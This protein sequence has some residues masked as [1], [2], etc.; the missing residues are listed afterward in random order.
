[1]TT[2]VFGSG[3]YEEVLG[4]RLRY[5]CGTPICPTGYVQ[6]N[7]LMY[8]KKKIRKYTAE[9]R[10][11]IHRNLKFDETVMTSLHMLA[12]AYL[13]SRSVEYMDNRV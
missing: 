11:E 10:E 1:M 4:I 13:P 8:K 9:G 2:K 7:N 6:I 12:R 5:I 3:S